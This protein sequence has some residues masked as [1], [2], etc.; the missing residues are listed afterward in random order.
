MSSQ[1]SIRAAGYR[2]AAGAL[3]LDEDDEML[4]RKARNGSL[5]AFET[6][7]SRY[8]RSILA[9]FLHLTASEVEALDFC[10]ATF[11]AAYR[12]LGR[13]K[14]ESLYIWLYQL[15]AEEWLRCQPTK[16][17]NQTLSEREQL[18]FVLKTR[19]QLSLRTVAQILSEPETTVA[20]TF[21]RAV[22]KL[23]AANH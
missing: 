17:G 21:S 15:A 4:V 12:T 5:P 10:R 1:T 19:E 7:S 14:K 6:L 23:Q 11:L 8:D 9:L 22:A 13:R 18:V 20:R 2:H 16:A 3:P